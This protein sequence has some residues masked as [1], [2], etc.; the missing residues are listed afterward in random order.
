MVNVTD[1]QR[2]QMVMLSG[3]NWSGEEIADELGVSPTTVYSHLNQI[4]NRSKLE[5]E[6]WR[7]VYWELV[8]ADVLDKHFRATVSKG[9]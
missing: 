2:A 6:E 7:A 3:L 9:L 1:K 5:S 4:E 8:L